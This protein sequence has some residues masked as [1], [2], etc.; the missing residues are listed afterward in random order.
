MM[1]EFIGRF[2]PLLVHLPIGILLVA[3]V[4]QLLSSKA[5]Y[6]GAAPAVNIAFL[7]GGIS[8]VV[9]CI[10]GYLLSL[11]GD[12]DEDTVSLHMW[13][14]IGVAFVS[15]VLYYA[16]IK[17][18]TQR[19]ANLMGGGLFLLIMITGHLGGTLTHGEG[20][21]TSALVSNNADSLTQKKIADIQQ[22]LVYADLVQ[23]L[24]QAKC[25]SCH[26]SKKQKGKLRLDKPDLIMKGG[27]DG[28]IIAPGKVDD[29]RLIKYIL[30][31]KENDKHM[32][33]K[34]KPQLTKDDVALLQWW[35]AQGASFDKKVNQLTQSEAIKPVLQ[36]IQ[37]NAASSVETVD[38]ASLVLQKE[39][40]PADEKTMAALKA[41][42][43]LVLQVSKTSNFVDV[44]F[45]NDTTI[46]DKDFLLLQ[47]L[48]QQVFSIKAN[49]TAITDSSLKIV[50]QFTN[51]VH[52]NM[53]HTRITDNGL[54]ALAVLPN[55]QTLN[56]VAT[57]VTANGIL[58]LQKIKTLKA[59]YLYQTNITGA[60]W[61]KLMTT[62]KGVQLDSGG[63]KVPTLVS[64]TTVVKQV[65]KN[66]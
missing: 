30:L 2:H 62:F 46:T 39:V 40:P 60:D 50:G 48:Q 25:Y 53:A 8:A 38:A 49:H 51:L 3:L 43:I 32:P 9:S 64:D 19:T 13:M 27:E 66:P 55:L 54:P 22:A 52:L 1:S 10:T 15:G 44:S 12:Y 11:S 57:G 33:P 59:V 61:A 20:Y 65:Q 34:E 63:Y 26:S 58:P 4:L 45:G 6:A 16:R 56:L 14:G 31:P 21:L 42:G 17:N 29:S 47:P 23:P 41:R 18:T 7:L 24:L 37:N 36:D 35:V 5:K 28:V